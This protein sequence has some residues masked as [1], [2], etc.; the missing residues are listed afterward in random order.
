MQSYS[1]SDT[2]V[3]L[4]TPP[5]Q[6]AI[7]VIRLSGAKAFSI[8]NGLVRN[9][10]FESLPSHSLH[11]AR[12]VIERDVID[13]AVFSLFKGPNSYTGED[14]IEISCHG[15][16]YILDTVLQQ[17]LALGARL[18]R[19]G[20]YTQRAYLNGKMDLTQAEAVADL[21]AAQTQAAHQTAMNHLKG[22]FSRE[23]KGMREELIKFS[24]L[25]EL[26][27]DFSEEDVEFADRGQLNELLGRLSESTHHL[28]STFRLGNALT[29]GI[30]VA[31]V[32]KPNVGK[33][34]L[35]NA[36]LNEERAIVSNIAGTTRDTITESLNISG[37]MFR[38]MDTAGIREH[39]SDLIEQLGMERSKNL[40]RQADLVLYL[41]DLQDVDSEELKE[42]INEFEDQGVQFLLVGNKV[43]ESTRPDLEAFSIIR[44]SARERNNI[45]ELKNQ[46]YKK[47]IG[48]EMNYE[49]SMI[50]SIR[51]YEALKEVKAALDDVRQGLEQSIS[52]ELLALDIR[53]ALQYLGE[54]TGEVTNED[55]LDYIFS[56]FCIG[57]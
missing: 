11:F 20:E 10:A 35:L 52:G 2:I 53:R 25:V 55:R 48:S 14:V 8:A 54:I 19:P 5:G 22:D 57:K 56:Q 28:L 37:V 43:D 41:F 36:L 4:A 31:I 17:C 6:G 26:E 46:L 12:I 9:K 1:S 51:H 3:A 34:T 45:E 39:S 38:L 47:A 27:L 21:I 7:G 44:I 23:L 32:G 24:A 42:R 18:A 13:E 50:T 16:P 29:R 30:Q 40:I 49:G 15:S 33:S